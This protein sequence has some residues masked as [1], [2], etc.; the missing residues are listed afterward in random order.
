M[1]KVDI[2]KTLKYYIKNYT[3]LGKL[4][5]PD[6]RD[7]ADCDLRTVDPPGGTSTSTYSTPRVKQDQLHGE[8]LKKKKNKPIDV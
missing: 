1:P 2:T 6:I 8:W 3:R 7:E 5:T 4:M